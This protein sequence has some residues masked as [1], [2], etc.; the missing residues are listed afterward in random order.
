MRVCLWLGVVLAVM[1]QGQGNEEIKRILGTITSSEVLRALLEYLPDEVPLGD[2]SA[3][4]L[5][6]QGDAGSKLVSFLQLQWFSLSKKA[7]P[8][9]SFGNS[10]GVSCPDNPSPRLD[11]HQVRLSNLHSL[12]LGDT[13]PSRLVLISRQGVVLDA[14]Y[15]LTFCGCSAW[16]R[17][18]TCN[19]LLREDAQVLGD[20]RLRIAQVALELDLGFPFGLR[21]VFLRNVE[22]TASDPPELKVEV[23]TVD[24]I[25]QAPEGLRYIWTKGVSNVLESNNGRT[26]L[27]QAVNKR[28]RENFVS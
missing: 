28:L 23:L 16:A 25:P 15:E 20:L 3:G 8:E 2:V 26:I 22:E 4:T 24:N 10:S 21:D 11:L 7:H 19:G 13:S 17:E 1:V 6:S 12:N 5:D 14:N 9:I 27:L 18:K